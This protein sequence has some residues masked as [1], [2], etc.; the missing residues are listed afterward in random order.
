MADNVT[1]NSMSGGSTVRAVN[2]SGAIETQVVVLD[3]G[4]SGAESLLA[5]GNP[6]PV[7]QTPVAASYTD[8]TTALGASATFTGSSRT[9]PSGAGYFNAVFWADQAGTAQIQLSDGTN[10]RTVASQTFVANG[11]VIMQLP[12][13]G[14][15]CRVQLVNGSVAETNVLVASSFTVG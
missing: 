10:W 3:I 2:K 9:P 6:M 12:C 8:T 1:L 5:S 13:F 4:G 15:N 14:L 7:A 11:S